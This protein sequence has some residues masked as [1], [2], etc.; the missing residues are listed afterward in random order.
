MRDNP[1]IIQ[2]IVDHFSTETDVSLLD[3]PF[4]KNPSYGY[5]SKHVHL[6]P[7]FGGFGRFHPHQFP[8][9]LG[10]EL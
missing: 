3:P 2:A 10:L 4:L 9:L 5:E 8:E 7:A 6:H 1:Q